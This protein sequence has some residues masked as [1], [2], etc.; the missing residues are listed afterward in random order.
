MSAEAAIAEAVVR[1]AVAV[2]GPVIREALAG[3]EPE[4]AVIERLRGQTLAVRDTTAEDA[5]RRARVEAEEA[6]RT[7]RSDEPTRETAVPR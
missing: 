3:G 2:L 6:A 7:A 1:V 5:A 4:A